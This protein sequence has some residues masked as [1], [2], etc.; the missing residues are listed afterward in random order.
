MPFVHALHTFVAEH[1]DELEFSAGEQIEVLERDDAFGDGW[2]RVSPNSSHHQADKA[3]GRNTKGEEGLFPATYISETPSTPDALGDHSSLT[4]PNHASLEPSSPKGSPLNDLAAPIATSQNF[5][6]KGDASD[7]VLPR[8]GPPT[9]G[10]SPQSGTS[11]RFQNHSEHFDDNRFQDNTES[12]RAGASDSFFQT[13]AATVGAAATGVTNVMGKTIGEIQDAIE[14]ITKPESDDEQELGIG[15]NTRARLAEQAK[16]ANEQRAKGQRTSGGVTDLIYSDESDE[17]EEDPRQILGARVDGTEKPNTNGHAVSPPALTTSPDVSSRDI[18]ER[19]LEPALPLPATPPLGQAAH[20]AKPPLSWT[21]NDVV[22]WAKLK[23]FDDTVCQRFRGELLSKIIMLT[24][25]HDIS[26]DLL[27]ELDTNLLKELDIPQFGKRVRISQAIS[28][29]RRPSSMVSS[30]SQQVPSG[31][32]NSGSSAMS[33]RGMSAPPSA[34]SQP[35]AT[36]PPTTTP[37]TPN[38]DNANYAV[39]SHSRKTSSTPVVLPPTME[40]IREVGQARAPTPNASDSI[41]TTRSTPASP[42]TPSSA[43]KRESTGS[44]GHKKGKPSIEKVE[45]LSFFGRNRKPA[46]R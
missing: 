12:P 25:E 28:E 19:S 20:P 44:V 23:G 8:S 35:F 22:D 46:P 42:V 5:S 36:T 39:W 3:K 38:S 6:P 33:A 32:A 40:A 18:H 2:W 11:E 37:T 21:V 29:L 10:F 31:M 16:L 41:S 17:E 13:A 45:R 7:R 27:L 30:G 24:T 43:T 1:A 26:G 9:S 34:I 15:S 4:P 14:S